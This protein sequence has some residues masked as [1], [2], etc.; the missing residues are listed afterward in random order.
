MTTKMRIFLIVATS[1]IWCLLIGYWAGVASAQITGQGFTYKPET[2]LCTLAAGPLQLSIAGSETRVCGAQ[3][4]GSVAS[5][6]DAVAATECDD[7]P[8]G[9]GG[10]TT[11]LFVQWDPSLGGSG[12][13]KCVEDA[14][15]GLPAHEADSTAHHTLG[16]VICTYAALHAGTCQTE[17]LGF[18][19]WITD[20]DVEYYD[21]CGND[22]VGGGSNSV[23]CVHDGTDWVEADCNEDWVSFRF[24]NTDLRTDVPAG[25]IFTSVLYAITEAQTDK[26][27]TP[28]GLRCFEWGD[29]ATHWK[30]R[31]TCEAT[32]ARISIDA[33]GYQQ[34]PTP[35]FAS[36]S[37]GLSEDSEISGGSEWL[38]W[39]LQ[40]HQVIN[41]RH[42]YY[43]ERQITLTSD[44]RFAPGI[45]LFTNLE[46]FWFVA[47]YTSVTVHTDR[48]SD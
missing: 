27:G 21:Q 22:A 29:D 35:L 15:A 36:V 6:T 23:R 5:I 32:N 19:A 24:K 40:H 28:A 44:T 13:W 43:L 7:I 25:S 12:E 34:K 42:G 11:T 46:L 38:Q 16:P 9:T 39:E 33:A 45:T 17:T 37:L 1:P 47:Q 26:T 31:H 20:G 14:V 10:G 8:G 3:S 48:C 18:E 2:P 30:M 41:E 4:P